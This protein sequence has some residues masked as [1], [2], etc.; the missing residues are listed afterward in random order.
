EEEE[1]EEEW[2]G[3]PKKKK[4]NIAK[5]KEKTDLSGGPKREMECPVCKK[6]RSSKVGTMITHLREVHGT[7]PIEVGIMFLCD[8]SYKSAS[9]SHF[10]YSQCDIR[11]FKIIHE[12]KV[13]VK[14]VQCE[15][16]MSS[17]YAYTGH[18]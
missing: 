17:I 3:S 10:L 6:F 14:C 9:N 1:E 4:I 12:K 11:N 16:L 2:D 7:T 18:L 13:G 15:S 5:K 8:C